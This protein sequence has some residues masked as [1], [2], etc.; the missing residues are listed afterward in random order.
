MESSV[1]LS[2]SLLKSEEIAPV[3]K[4]NDKDE[5]TNYERGYLVE[6]YLVQKRD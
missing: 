3:E 1:K 4:Q 6:Y 5:D 2:T